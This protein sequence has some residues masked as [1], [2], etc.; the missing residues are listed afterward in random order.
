MIFGTVFLDRTATLPYVW[1]I[2]HK[3]WRNLGLVTHI[4]IK[5][6]Q[7]VGLIN[8]HILIYRHARCDYMLWDRPLILLRFLSIFILYYWPF[9][10][11]LLYL[12]QTF[13]DCV[14]NVMEHS[15]ILLR[16]FLGIFIYYWRPFISE[17]LYL[18]QQARSWPDLH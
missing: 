7:N 16:F 18:H 13:I 8:T 9:K 11:E 3:N 12:H 10:S 5:L 15:L 2:Y 17:V 4:F 6:S 1:K 14:S